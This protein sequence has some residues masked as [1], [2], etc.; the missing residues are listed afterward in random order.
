MLGQGSPRP[1][2]LRMCS[3]DGQPSWK[4]LVPVIRWLSSCSLGQLV[5]QLVGRVPTVTMYVTVRD[6][7][8]S[9]KILSEVHNKLRKGS[10]ATRGQASRPESTTPCTK[11]II[12]KMKNRGITQAEL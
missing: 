2:S 7:G 1:G 8:L 4:A 11:G 10:V 12:C 3:E 6:A 5:H 9:L